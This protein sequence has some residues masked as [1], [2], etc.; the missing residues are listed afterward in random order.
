MRKNIR[1]RFWVDIGLASITGLL[2]LITPIFPDWLELA[3]GW[4]L[5]RHD[6]SLERVI[7]CGLVVAT[8]LLFAL[9]AMEWRRAAAVPST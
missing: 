6:G 9:A 4:D 5:D 3:A 1:R 8:I 7:V 2:L